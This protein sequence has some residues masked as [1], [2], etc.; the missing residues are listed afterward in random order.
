[1]GVAV[2][3]EGVGQPG[4]E[5]GGA[6]AGQVGHQGVDPARRQHEGRQHRQ[7]VREDAVAAEEVERRLQQGA[8]HVRVG[9][10]ERVLE[11]V[12][13]VRLV[14]VQRVGR[15]RVLHP[16]RDPDLQQGIAAERRVRSQVGGHRP[17]HG[18]GR[19]GVGQRDQPPPAPL[20]GRRQPH[21]RDPPRSGSGLARGR[22]SRQRVLLQ[23]ALQRREP[24]LPQIACGAI[25]TVVESRQ[26]LAERGCEERGRPFHRGEFDSS[27]HA[28]VTFAW[29]ARGCQWQ[30]ADVRCR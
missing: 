6:V 27:R 17:G 25:E 23:R 9:V 16:A 26:V 20:G 30:N 21:R 5:G 29:R 18:D 22:V 1:M 12:E 8:R 7:V 15:Q 14:E 4:Q 13:D 28:H 3:Q 24:P 11:R 19:H 2:G 10:S